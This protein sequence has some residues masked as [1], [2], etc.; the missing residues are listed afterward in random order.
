MCGK[1][2]P[3]TANIIIVNYNESFSIPLPL[4]VLWN[5]NLAVL[6]NFMITENPAFIFD[7]LNNKLSRS[8]TLETIECS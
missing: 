4:R 2:T 3:K 6:A 5:K 7:V 1:Y 8:I